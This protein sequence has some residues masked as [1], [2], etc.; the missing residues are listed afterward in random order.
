MKVKDLNWQTVCCG[1]HDKMAE[2]I[3]PSDGVAFIVRVDNE[4]LTYSIKKYQ[5]DLKTLIVDSG[6]LSEAEANS[7]LLS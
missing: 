6:E 4:T 5:P 1:E 7:L 3:R 2:Y